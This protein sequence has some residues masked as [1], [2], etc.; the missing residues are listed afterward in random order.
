M[1]P[2]F[3]TTLNGV[4]LGRIIVPAAI[5][6]IAVRYTTPAHFRE[7]VR[8]TLHHPIRALRRGTK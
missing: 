1:T 8:E 3:L 4:W 2:E 6:I 7:T 5:L